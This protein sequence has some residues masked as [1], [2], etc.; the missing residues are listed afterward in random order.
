VAGL[1]RTLAGIP[2]TDL[3]SLIARL[4]PEPGTAETTLRD[5]IERA[6]ATA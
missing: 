6:R 2:G 1:C 4:C 3:P 5:L